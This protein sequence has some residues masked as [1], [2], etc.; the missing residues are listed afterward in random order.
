MSVLLVKY[1]AIAT[2]P[3]SSDSYTIFCS[4]Q[5]R[6]TLV[7]IPFVLR[8]S[9]SLKNNNTNANNSNNNKYGYHNMAPVVLQTQGSA[10]NTA[11]VIGEGEI[12][13]N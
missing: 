2:C 3:A 4:L 11:L 8:I 9:S 1:V 5:Q 13:L 7:F 6:N 12:V 10:N